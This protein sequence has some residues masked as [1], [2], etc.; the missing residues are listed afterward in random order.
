MSATQDN[1]HHMIKTAR[2]GQTLFMFDDGTTPWAEAEIKK[3]LESGQC[4]YHPDGSREFITCDVIFDPTKEGSA[5]YKWDRSGDRVAYNKTFV[6]V[7]PDG[8]V[9]KEKMR[10]VYKSF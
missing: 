7:T 10:V 4:R 5:R 6:K 3:L 1:L 9:T 8:T 2:V